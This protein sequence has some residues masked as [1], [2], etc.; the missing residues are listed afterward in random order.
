MT[1]VASMRGWLGLVIDEFTGTSL[2]YEWRRI[3]QESKRKLS[4]HQ[5]KNYKQNVVD[6][7]GPFAPIAIGSDTK[8]DRPN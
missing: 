7:E 1:T 4:A 5:F 6:N 3:R 8:D 2:R